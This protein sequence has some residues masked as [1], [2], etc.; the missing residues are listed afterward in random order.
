MKLRIVGDAAKPGPERW[1][2]P[3]EPAAPMTVV[4]D[5]RGS[6]HD[7]S[8]LR[9]L[10]QAG[11]SGP[12]LLA[13][14]G[15]P[16]REP[17]E[18]SL[19]PG[20]LVRGHGAA[21]V[22]ALQAA[23]GPPVAVGAAAAA[24]LDGRKIV[25]LWGGVRDARDGRPWER[26]TMVLVFS[27]TKGMAAT[28]V[29]VAHAKGLFGYD[30]P[31]SDHWPEFAQA[32]KHAIVI[33]ELLAHQAG[34]PFV[35]EDLDVDTMADLD[36]LADVLARQAP[37]W[38]PGTRH[39]YHAITIGWYEGELIRRVDPAGRSLGRFFAEEVAEP[40]EAEFHI[41]LPEDISDERIATVQPA[42]R[43]QTLLG[44]GELPLRLVASLLNPRSP[45]V[46]TLTTPTALFDSASWNGRR[47]LEIEVPAGNGVGEV[48]AVARIYGSIA[49]G[50][51]ELGLD[52]AT[53]RAMEAPA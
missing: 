8:L 12:V 37:V 53:L 2:E 18:E 19:G 10:R 5:V 39:G 36:A 1:P 28:A 26:D 42:K 20:T 47:L 32:G 24:Y 38:E 7:R 45:T 41:G 27:S 33:R 48:R 50:G 25:D 21:L 35:D 52:A 9:E 11:L 44:L 40:L 49:A 4:H 6:S 31:V 23:A 30:D 15:A 17:L 43:S 14:E 34:L 22:T 51:R 29:H 3:L 16:L 13:Q 46:R